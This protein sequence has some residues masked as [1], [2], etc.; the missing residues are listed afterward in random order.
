MA[1]DEMDAT[2]EPKSSIDQYKAEL[3][4]DTELNLRN[5]RDKSLTLSSMQA[6]WTG[7]YVEEKKQLKRLLELRQK[8]LADKAAKN[9]NNGTDAF[10]KVKAGSVPDE[11]LKKIDKVK[12]ELELSIEFIHEAMTILGQMGFNIKNSIEIFKMENA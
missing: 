3:E 7:Y 9:L 6:K 11:T 2:E 8:Y 12:N 4:R 5:I 10:A 1:E